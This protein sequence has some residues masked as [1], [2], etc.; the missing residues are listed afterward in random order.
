MLN[1][2]MMQPIGC[3]LSGWVFCHMLLRPTVLLFCVFIFSTSYGQ[4][5]RTVNGHKINRIDKQ[6]RKQGEWIYFDDAGNAKLSCLYEND[7]CISPLVFY[8][9][10]DTAFVRV[11]K[12]DS[13]QPFMVVHNQKRFFGSIIR[14]SDTTTTFEFEENEPSEDVVRKVASYQNFRLE[15]VYNFSKKNP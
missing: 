10:G 2:K 7:V 5:E 3:Y 12:T 9:N 4:T 1:S 6:K 8:E 15:P 13:V 11:I 14:S